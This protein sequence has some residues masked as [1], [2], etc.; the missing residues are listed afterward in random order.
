MLD[1]VRRGDYDISVVFW[2]VE[3]TGHP[4][5]HLKSQFHSKSELN[6]QG[7]ANARFDALV[8]K[9]RT[10]DPGPEWAATYGEALQVLQRDAPIL[11]L[12]PRVF[13]V[14]S[15]DDLAGYRIH[16]SAF[17]YDFQSGSPFQSRTR[18]Q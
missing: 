4:D 1:L 16:T 9:V 15:N 13:V 5:L 18:S 8:D 2:T 10:L 11:R 12:V 14:D 6:Y 7:W 17:F 3:M